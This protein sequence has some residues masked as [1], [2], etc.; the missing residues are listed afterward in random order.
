MPEAG[1]ATRFVASGHCLGSVTTY[2]PRMGHHGPARVGSVQDGAETMKRQGPIAVLAL[3]LGLLL[4]HAPAAQAQVASRGSGLAEAELVK[5][6][7]SLRSQ[8]RGQAEAA[9]SDEILSG[10]SAA[11]HRIAIILYASGLGAA[12][13]AAPAAE[14]ARHLYHARAPPAA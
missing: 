11:G 10:S 12:Y 9:D 2:V 6:G 7:K 3:L 8:S 14:A 5:S 13:A 1:A 4:A